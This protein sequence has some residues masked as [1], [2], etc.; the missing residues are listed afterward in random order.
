ML[1]PYASPAVLSESQST[2]GVDKLVDLESTHAGNVHAGKQHDD[3]SYRKDKSWPPRAE[4]KK[5]SYSCEGDRLT[6][7]SYLRYILY[8]ANVHTHDLIWFCHCLV[9]LYPLTLRH[10]PRHTALI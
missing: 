4:T 2:L 10:V 7:R 9:D 3:R 8:W 5:H 1:S 6:E